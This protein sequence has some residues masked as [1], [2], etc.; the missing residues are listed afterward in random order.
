MAAAAQTQNILLPRRLKKGDTLAVIATSMPVADLSHGLNAE[1]VW[2]KGVSLLEAEGFNVKLMPNAKKKWRYLA[3]TDDERLS[4]LHA[5]FE[6]DD[7]DGILCARGG[8]GTTRF[9][10]RVDMNVIR[11][12]PKVFIGFSDVTALLVAFYQQ[13]GL[14]GFYGPMLT[15]NLVRNEPY[16]QKILFEMTRGDQPVPY[17]VPNNPTVTPHPYQ[18]LKPGSVE[19]PLT[20]GNLS[21]LAALCGTP[22]QCNAEGHILFI[23]DWQEAYY[24]VDRKFQQLKMA[25]VFK[26]IKGLLLCDFSEVTADCAETLPE[27][28]QELTADLNVPVGYG[29]SVGHGEETATLP[30]G[31]QASFNAEAGTVTILE[32]PVL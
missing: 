13:V 9:L 23:E 10:S 8:Y 6:D 19:A 21:L 20:G 26:G 30:I 1:E 11:S 14:A 31:I 18:C 12:N 5:A 24:A 15:S 2:N 3:G 28:L 16:S 4:D 7:V 22:Y 29:F 25:G 32:S 17:N 27:I